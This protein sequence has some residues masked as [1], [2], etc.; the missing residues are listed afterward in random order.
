MPKK[1]TTFLILIVLSSSIAGCSTVRGFVKR[2][3]GYFPPEKYDFIDIGFVANDTSA[4]R[5]GCA[6]P[7]NR[8]SSK[9]SEVNDSTDVIPPQIVR[10]GV[11]DYPPV[12][13]KRGIEGSV[14][15]GMYLDTSGEAVY[16]V[17]LKTSNP[18]FN[19]SALYGAVQ[20]VFSP[21]IENGK[22]IPFWVAVPFRFRLRQPNR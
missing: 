17:V 6:V 18:G 12:A 15:V 21:A 2:E 14:I 19:S 1:S 9:H 7:L 10:P 4:L 13:Q 11:P 16:A 5:I 22:P 8:P 20:Y 3:S